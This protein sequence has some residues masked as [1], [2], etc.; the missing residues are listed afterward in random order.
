M[1]LFFLGVDGVVPVAV[2]L[3]SGDGYG[4]FLL[5][6]EFDFRGVG[7]GVEL[8]AYGE[9]CCGVGDEVDDLVGFEWSTSPVEG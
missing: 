6:G 8:A 4:C 1:T 9:S 5:F 2:E 3:V 7:V